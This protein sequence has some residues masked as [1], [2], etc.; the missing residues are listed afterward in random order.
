MADQIQIVISG[1]DN[2]PVYYALNYAGLFDGGLVMIQW[3]ILLQYKF[4]VW[5]EVPTNQIWCMKHY[6]WPHINLPEAV[7][8][9]NMLL[10]SHVQLLDGLLLWYH[11]CSLLLCMAVVNLK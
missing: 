10:A 5:C 4:I 3:G 8:Y 6:N 11:Q 2:V 7:C 1:S 9:I